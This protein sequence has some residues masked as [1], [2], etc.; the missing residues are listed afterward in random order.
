V[1]FAVAEQSYSFDV[2]M[3]GET[4]AAPSAKVRAF[5]EKSGFGRFVAAPASPAVEASRAALR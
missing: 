5:L 4:F 2:P 3:P 1:G